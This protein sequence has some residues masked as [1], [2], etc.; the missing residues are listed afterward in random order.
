MT[1]KNRSFTKPVKCPRCGQQAWWS[2]LV[3]K[4]SCLG[5]EIVKSPEE[6]LEAAKP[7]ERKEIR[8]LQT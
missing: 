5:C 6:L 4:L 8:K 1:A 3:G 7:W 2:D